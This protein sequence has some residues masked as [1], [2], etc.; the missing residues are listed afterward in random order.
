MTDKIEKTLD[1]APTNEEGTH[2]ALPAV[3][4]DKPIESSSDKEKIEDDFDQGRESLHELI[5]K[6]HD[7]I[8]DM[9]QIAKQSQHPTAYSTLNSMLKT[10]ADMHKDLMTMHKQ[11]KNLLTSEP[12][13]KKAGE[14]NNDNR[15]QNIFVGTT[16]ELS[17]LIN[18]NNEDSSGEEEK[19][20]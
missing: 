20:V 16:A 11:K 17:A 3:A 7:A 6:G 18:K 12:G 9:L 13:K 2:F 15:T 10:M 14:V 4:N 5:Q 1:L 8:E 19:D